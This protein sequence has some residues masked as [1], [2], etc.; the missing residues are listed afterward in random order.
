HD[1]IRL[2]VEATIEHQIE[3]A[4]RPNLGGVVVAAILPSAGPAVL[5]ALAATP[6]AAIPDD[7]RRQLVAAARKVAAIR[8]PLSRHPRLSAELAL[9]LYVW[10]GQ[11]LRPPLAAV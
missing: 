1:L 5:T 10:V 6:T 11:R 4:R 9:Q 3:V 2:L 8:S 7:D